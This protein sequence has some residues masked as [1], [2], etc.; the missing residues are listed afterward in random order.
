MSGRLLGTLGALF[1]IAHPLG[2]A[3]LSNLSSASSS[4][5]PDAITLATTPSAAASSS[6]PSP[7]SPPPAASPSALHRGGSAAA[8]AG[9]LSEG[10]GNVLPWGELL[11]GAP[12]TWAEY[13]LLVGNHP[14]GPYL[15]FLILGE[16]RTSSAGGAWIELWISQ[17]PG[18]A[19]QAYRMLLVDHPTRGVEVR[20]AFARLLGGEVQELD[21]ADLP[22]IA[23]TPRG[24]GSSPKTHSS[25]SEPSKAQPST[26]E[27]SGLR[28]P[29]GRVA[30]GQQSAILTPAGSFEA[31]LVTLDTTRG[32]TKAWFTPKI[33]LFGLARLEAGELGLEL[34]SFGEGGASVVPPPREAA[35]APSAANRGAAN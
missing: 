4:T 18:S 35:P 30:K 3:A 12:G 26:S 11:K 5:S 21:L 25:K 33:P 34:H 22:G 24:E 16:E 28:P 1:F 7:A 9:A 32:G 13:A 19:T 23:P 6:A 20:R 31:E 14:V 10:L 17:R 29:K 2:A 15:R 8:A 27:P